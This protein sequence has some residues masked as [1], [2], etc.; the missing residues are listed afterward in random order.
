M[1]VGEQAAKLLIEKGITIAVS[2]SCTGGLLS[3]AI[4]DF[5]GASEVF[6]EGCV[7]YSNNAKMR[8]LGV[9]KETLDNYGAVSHETAREMAAGIALTAGTDIGISTTGIAGPGGGTEEK[10]VGLVYI[11]FYMGG[12]VRSR[13]L[14]LAGDREQIRRSAVRSALEWLIFEVERMG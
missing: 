6:E 10:P 1:T 7:T 3:S 9:S 14:R 8:R 5:P 11:G 13:E 2:E 12:Q 4:I